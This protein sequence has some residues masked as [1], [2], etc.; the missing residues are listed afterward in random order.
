[1]DEQMRNELLMQLCLMN[2]DDSKVVDEYILNDSITDIN[3]ELAAYKYQ[4]ILMLEEMINLITNGVFDESLTDNL[5]RLAFYNNVTTR[6][7][8]D[9]EYA[10]I[11]PELEE[12]SADVIEVLQAA[13]SIINGDSDSETPSS[14]DDSEIPE[15]LIKKVVEPIQKFVAAQQEAQQDESQYGPPVNPVK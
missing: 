1:M 4:V 12:Y 6:Y 15:K 5:L 3:P 8:A 9:R 2:G 11:N 14:S 10:A 7:I 13:I